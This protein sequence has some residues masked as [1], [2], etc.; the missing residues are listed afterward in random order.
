MMKFVLGVICAGA[1]SLVV[2]AKP[3]LPT[4]SSD[5]AVKNISTITGA[6]G[7]SDGNVLQWLQNEAGAAGKPAPSTSFSNYTGGPIAAG[8]YLVLHYRVGRGGTQ[9]SGGGLVV[10]YFTTAVSS[11]LVPANGLGKNGNGGLSFARL[12]D[13]NTP[14]QSRV[15]DGGTSLLLLGLGLSVLGVCARSKRLAY[16]SQ[17]NTFMRAASVRL[18]LFSV[19]GPPSRA[20]IGSFPT[21]QL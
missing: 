13:A 18:L 5:F 12:F 9:G 16:R 4:F 15:P 19:G 20:P 11:Y 7:L 1:L 17:L 2:N 10:I 6:P 14:P 21:P 8:D 3:T